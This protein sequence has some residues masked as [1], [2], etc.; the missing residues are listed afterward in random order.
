MLED[1]KMKTSSFKGMLHPV[2]GLLYVT[3][4]Y[5]KK[6]TDRAK[7]SSEHQTLSGRTYFNDE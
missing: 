3:V 7:Q 2:Y 1:I 4:D 5:Y 6:K